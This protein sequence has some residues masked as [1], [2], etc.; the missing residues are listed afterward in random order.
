MIIKRSLAQTVDNVSKTFPVLLVTGPRQ[1]GKTTLLEACMDADIHY[2]S[3]DTLNIRLLAQQDP[4]LFLQRYPPPLFID[5]I[6][7]APQ[8]FPYIK[9]MVDKIRQPGLF[10]LTGS[11]RFHLMRNVSESLA[12]RVGIINLLGLSNAE[13]DGYAEKASSFLPTSDYIANIETYAQS[14]SLLDVYQRIWRGSFPAVA[15]DENIKHDI[16][17]S[18]YLQTYLERDVRDLARVG[19]EGAFVSFVRALAARTGQL[20][21]MSEVGRDIGIDNKT[22]KVWLSI[23]ETSGLIYLLKPYHNNLSKRLIKSPKIYFLDTGLCCYL[24]Q[25]TSPQALEAGAMSGAILETYIFTEILKSYWHTGCSENFYFYRDKD[26]KEIDLLIDRDGKLYP[27]EFKKTA[28]PS[29]HASKHF[30]VLDRLSK[31]IG[32]GGV[33]CLT[34]EWIPLSQTVNAIPVGYV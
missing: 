1:V 9:A 21:N 27:V 19:D 2:V 18:S 14:L 34:D 17:Y 3:L 22:V 15:L 26:Q 7:Y 4:A 11:Q 24:T 6:Q 29:L 25:W 13:L 32:Q 16:F 12:G 10:W 31:D 23:L 20:L 30:S 5:E 28:M 33:I 8:L